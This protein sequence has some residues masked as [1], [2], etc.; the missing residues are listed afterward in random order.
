MSTHGRHD[1][2]ITGAK[3]VDGTGNPWFY[4]DVAV[5]GERVAAVTPAGRIER[6]SAREV[7]DAT[8]MAVCPGFIDIQS[9][10]LIPLFEDG[11]SL[12]K[13][14]QGVTTEVLG[15]GWTPAPFGGQIREV[16]A[17][18]ADTNPEMIER[19][20]SWARFGDWLDWQVGQGV[21]VNVG[22]F[23]GGGTLREYVK[24]WELGEQTPDEMEQ[25]R[26]IV[27]DAME[28][29][30]FG[31]ATAL[32]YPPNSFTTDPELYETCRVIADYGGVYVTHMRSEADDFLEELA[33]TIDLGRQTG[34]ALELYHLKVGGA[35]NWHKMATAIQ[36]VNDARD[37]GIDVTAD[38]YPYIAGGTGL[39]SALPNWAAAGGKLLDNL[40][41]P[42][43]RERI[44]HE[45][46]EPTG[47]WEPLATLAG[48]EGVLITDLRREGNRQFSGKR[49]AEIAEARGQHW[50]DC[51]MDLVLE[52]GHWI[53]TI[54]FMMTEDNLPTQLQQP[55]MKIS[56]DA[57]GLD[58]AR[59]SG[60]VTHPRSYG[61]YPRVLGKYVREDGVLT[62][63]DA[64]RKMTSAVSDRLS[65]RERGLLRAGHYADIVIFD[66]E[67]IAD[68]A[69]FE[70]P[71][72]LSTGV[73]DVWV[74]GVRVLDSGGHT[75]ATPGMAVY[76][77]GRAV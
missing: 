55:W 6:D 11:R 43:T 52:E 24:G 21:S 62:L 65:L 2:L 56:T 32:I 31:V 25:M 40:R 64:V 30:A 20:K 5:R 46:L 72:Q 63:E 41:D 67:T 37:E 53:F 68:N 57:S 4:G 61:T 47:G 75:N 28:D 70:S 22:S 33:E 76:G 10:S 66:P 39:A 27:R 29:G 49:L 71:H 8:G 38:M 50:T 58:P 12:S 23:L 34:C 17:G 74:N 15:E 13:V 7:I 26:R 45:L 54:Y 36:M 60:T 48:P 16:L 44:R 14:T 1:L 19:I 69:T 77:P 73:R 18:Y 3:V 59:D 35:R 51:L 9:H 42:E